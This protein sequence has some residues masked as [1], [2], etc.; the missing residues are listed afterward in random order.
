[1]V[2]YGTIPYRRSKKIVVCGLCI[3]ILIPTEL[4]DAHILMCLLVAS[5]MCMMMYFTFY[6]HINDG[7]FM[8][9][10]LKNTTE[11]VRELLRT[12]PGSSWTPGSS[13]FS[14][15]RSNQTSG[16]SI[17]SLFETVPCFVYDCA[18]MVCNE[19]YYYT[20]TQPLVD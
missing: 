2:P 14:C 10:R 3:F 13:R 16:K 9:K 4:S 15:N 7:V 5:R 20:V 17:T 1:M 6:A 11:G 12:V 18:I 8:S 19:F